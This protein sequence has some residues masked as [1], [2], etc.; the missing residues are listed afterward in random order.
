MHGALRSILALGLHSKSHCFRF[1][2]SPDKVT[3]E[4]DASKLR[5]PIRVPSFAASSNAYRAR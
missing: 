2:S 1:L 3:Q 5:K 4:G